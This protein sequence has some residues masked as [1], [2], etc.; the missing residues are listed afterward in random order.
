M[1]LTPQISVDKIV[2]SPH[3]AMLGNGLLSTCIWYLFTGLNSKADRL[4]L[5]FHAT[6]TVCQCVWGVLRPDLFLHITMKAKKVTSASSPETT[7]IYTPIKK[8]QVK[9]HL[10]SR[11]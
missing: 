5:C 8:S 7:G 3:N 1:G 4:Q 9:F 11:H 6:Y 2:A 10:C